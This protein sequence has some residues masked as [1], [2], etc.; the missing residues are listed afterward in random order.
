MED[1]AGGERG[2]VAA[3]AALDLGPG[4]EPRALDAAAQGADEPGG[5]AQLLD[6][7]PALLLGAVGLPELRLAQALDP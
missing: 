2:L 3:D 7:R 6:R 4:A 5:P 1:R